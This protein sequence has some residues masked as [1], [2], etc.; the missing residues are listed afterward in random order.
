MVDR[1]EEAAARLQHAPRLGQR[2]FP[3]LQ[4]VQHERGDDV[5]ECAVGEW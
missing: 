4:V 2:R 1:R 5:I 3:V